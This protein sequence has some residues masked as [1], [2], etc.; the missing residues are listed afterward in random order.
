MPILNY[1]SK[2]VDLNA[3]TITVTPLT[4]RSHM[5]FLNQLY[6]WLSWQP[7]IYENSKES[8]IQ[9]WEISN[10]GCR[11]NKKWKP[12]SARTKSRFS[13][14]DP[15]SSPKELWLNPR[16]WM[17]A[18]EALCR[19]LW[20]LLSA[21]LPTLCSRIRLFKCWWGRIPQRN[22]VKLTNCSLKPRDCPLLL[23]ADSVNLKTALRKVALSTHHRPQHQLFPIKTHRCLAMETAT[24]LNA[25]ICK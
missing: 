14:V 19:L 4:F 13:V 2:S 11:Q 17:V 23:V 18:W 21:S 22:W 1:S 6:L 16:F 12:F 5:N 9:W 10:L 25:T 7:R 3:S 8:K 20:A 24:P 15:P